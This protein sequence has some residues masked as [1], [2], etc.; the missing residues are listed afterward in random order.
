MPELSVVILAGG[1]AT[2]LPGKLERLTGGMPLIVR[3]YENTRA[4]GPVIISAKGGFTPEIDRALA[5]PVVIDRWPARGPLGGLVSAFGVATTPRVF[6]VAGDAPFVDAGVFAQLDERWDDAAE[7]VVAENRDG[8]VEPL[9][10]I[11]DRAAFLTH[12][13][14]V[15]RGGSGS[16]RDVVARLCT[17]RVRLR[18]ERALRSINTPDDARLLEDASR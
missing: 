7:A 12:A 18:D 8:R 1:E 10:A 17:R 5:A 3:V 13:L 4:I 6:V 15:L 14:S 16:V 9:C 11:Y 2:R